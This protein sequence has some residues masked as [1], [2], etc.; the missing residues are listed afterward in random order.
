MK[1]IVRIATKHK[2]GFTEELNSFFQLMKA[3]RK[4]NTVSA[5]CG[6]FRFKSFE[7]AEKWRHKMMRGKYPD[8]Q[9]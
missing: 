7:E 5:P 1:I 9:Q 3:F 4:D 8:L 2:K 6:I